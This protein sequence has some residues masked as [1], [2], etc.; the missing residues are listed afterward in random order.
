[1]GSRYRNYSSSLLRG[2]GC[3]CRT[4]FSKTMNGYGKI[5]PWFVAH[6]QCHVCGR[7]HTDSRI[8]RG[9]LSARMPADSSEVEGIL[10]VCFGGSHVRM[11]KE[12]PA[13]CQLADALSEMMEDG[14]PFLPRSFGVEADPRLGAS[15]CNSEKSEFQ[16]HAAREHSQFLF[17]C[18]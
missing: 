5:P 18:F 14:A 9:F 12:T 13:H 7:K 10:D 4:N 2:K 11:R 3:E 16:R 6:S 15:I 1:M 17:A 8:V